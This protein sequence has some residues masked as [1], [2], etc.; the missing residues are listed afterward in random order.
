MALTGSQL[1]D[2]L[3]GLSDNFTDAGAVTFAISTLRVDVKFTEGKI[4]KN[5]SVEI[6]ITPGSALETELLKAV[7]ATVKA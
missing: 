3:L 5:K 4:V 7:E 2:Y 6:T 1:K